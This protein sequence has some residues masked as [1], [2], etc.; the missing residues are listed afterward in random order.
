MA[1]NG[2][3][4]VLPPC[5]L[6]RPDSPHCSGHMDKC[7]NVEYFPLYIECEGIEA[8]AEGDLRSCPTACGTDSGP[9]EAVRAPHRNPSADGGSPRS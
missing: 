2:A 1:L 9:A 7:L 3:R 5:N 4:I 8:N 6:G